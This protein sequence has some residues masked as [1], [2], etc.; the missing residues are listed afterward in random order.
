MSN[1]QAEH[2]GHFIVPVSYYIGTFIALLILT[3]ITVAI[4]RFDFG[5]FNLVIAML[6]A[7]IKATFV[8]L[9]FMGLKWDRGF[10]A[11]ILLGT[12][13][14]L[15]IFFLLTFSDIAFRGD[16]DPIEKGVYGIKSPVKIIQSSDHSSSHH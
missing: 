8:G 15:T 6:V 10:N 1:N 16:L 12:L 4:S 2:Q 14:F 13:L 9:I 5:S 3:F 7:V 11:L